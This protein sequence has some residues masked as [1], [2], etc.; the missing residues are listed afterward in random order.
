MKNKKSVRRNT[1]LTWYAFILLHHLLI[2]S[3]L[4]T[5]SSFFQPQFSRKMQHYNIF[6]LIGIFGMLLTYKCVQMF[7][8]QPIASS[9]PFIVHSKMEMCLMAIFSW[10]NRLLR[11]N[12]YI[13]FWSIEKIVRLVFLGIEGGSTFGNK[14]DHNIWL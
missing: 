2:H 6:D 11:L 9:L 13:N 8:V 7:L 12:V 14:Q 10:H 3:I 5:K 1:D 4:I